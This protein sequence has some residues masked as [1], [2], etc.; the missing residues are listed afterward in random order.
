MC[1]CAKPNV[2]G[3]PGYSWDGKNVSTRGLSAGVPADSGAGGHQMSRLALDHLKSEQ[4]KPGDRWHY[5]EPKDQ[6]RIPCDACNRAG[7]FRPATVCHHAGNP[8]PFFYYCLAHGIDRGFSYGK[9]V[10]TP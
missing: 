2:N 8:H 7:L 4:A 1:C 6:D 5:V 10:V 9:T 3:E